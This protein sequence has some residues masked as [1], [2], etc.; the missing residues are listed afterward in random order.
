M[1]AS[2]FIK[3]LTLI[4]FRLEL[5]YFKL[6]SSGLG[7]TSLSERYLLEIKV[8][9]LIL[10]MSFYSGGLCI[11]TIQSFMEQIKLFKLSF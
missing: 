8:Q 4:T 10:I 11:T 7:L 5:I 9:Q 2:I 6:W 1:E 3:I